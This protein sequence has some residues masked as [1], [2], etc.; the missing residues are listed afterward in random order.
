L[1]DTHRNGF[2]TAYL[3]QVLTGSGAKAVRERGGDQ[4]AGFGVFAGKPSDRVT[5]WIHQLMD[6]GLLEVS[7][8]TYPVIELTDH[9]R[10]ALRERAEI[11]LVEN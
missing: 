10:Q 3:V 8:G 7:G 11:R 9:G 6:L 5:T 4:A 1:L 2:G